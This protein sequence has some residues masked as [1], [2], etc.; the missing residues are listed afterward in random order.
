MQFHQLVRQQLQRPP[1]PTHGR[2]AAR[3]RHQPR[4]FASVEFELSGFAARFADQ[5]GFQPSFDQTLSQ[6]MDLGPADAEGLD[7][8]GVG[9]SWASLAFVCFQEHPGPQGF[10]RRC[11]PIS[12]QFFQFHPLLQR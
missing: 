5:R 9:P 2:L 3:Q 12:D 6:A 4:L 11:P 8:L 10:L 1:R 7:N